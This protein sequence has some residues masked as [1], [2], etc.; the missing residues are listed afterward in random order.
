[1]DEKLAKNVL[2]QM[3]LCTKMVM[4]QNEIVKKWDA[5]L[6]QSVIGNAREL[7]GT[8]R[9]ALLKNLSRRGTLNLQQEGCASITAK[10]RTDIRHILV[11]H[12]G[13]IDAENNVTFLQSSL[14]GRRILIRLIDNDALQF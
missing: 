11:G 4:Q 3:D 10:M 7:D 1:M 13:I 8:A 5:I 14:S 9:N 6:A 2:N 12:R